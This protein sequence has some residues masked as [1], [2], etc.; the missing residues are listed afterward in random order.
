MGFPWSPPCRSI[1][2]PGAD[3]IHQ[4]VAAR[5]RAGEG[6]ADADVSLPR[7]GLPEHRVEGDQLQHMDGL[8]AELGRNPFD[9]LLRDKAE[10]L[11]NEME[12]RQSRAPPGHRVVRYDFVDLG[13]EAGGKGHHLSKEPSWP[14]SLPSTKKIVTVLFPWR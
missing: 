8:D 6:A 14:A 1:F 7:R 11:L 4:L 9:R 2:A 3:C 10:M 12:Q 5:H 13:F